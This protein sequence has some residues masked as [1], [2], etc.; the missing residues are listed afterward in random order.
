MR[1]EEIVGD[2][3]LTLSASSQTDVHLAAGDNA[4]AVVRVVEE[5][6][7]L[8]RPLTVG[9]ENQSKSICRGGGLSQICR[10]AQAIS[11]KDRQKHAI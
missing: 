2:S 9:S 3:D 7:L 8:F 1:Y 10:T 11:R 5:L 4:L 6:H